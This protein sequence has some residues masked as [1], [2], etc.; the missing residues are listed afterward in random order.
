MQYHDQFIPIKLL[1]PSQTLPLTVCLQ[2]HLY[3]GPTKTGNVSGP[4]LSKHVTTVDYP[5]LCDSTIHEGPT[6]SSNKEQSATI[7]ILPDCLWSLIIV[8]MDCA[9]PT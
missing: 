2:W 8:S 5:Q 4:D 7:S 9:A 6:P 3:T 1:P